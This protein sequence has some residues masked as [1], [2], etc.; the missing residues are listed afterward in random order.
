[1]GAVTFTPAESTAAYGRV[2]AGMPRFGVDERGRRWIEGTLAMSSS[3]ATN[4]D[5]LALPQGLNRVE[6]LFVVGDAANTSG[7]SYRLAGTAEAPKVMAYDSNATE[8][9]N[10]TNLSARSAVRVRIVGS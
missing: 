3:Y 10:A 6:Q 4:G 1:M 7:L 9:T 8:V 2:P 5:T